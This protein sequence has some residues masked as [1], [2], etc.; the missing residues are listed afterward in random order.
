MCIVADVVFY[1]DNLI[2]N[3]SPS[4]YTLVNATLQEDGSIIIQPKGMVS[5]Y[6]SLTGG[7][8]FA[9]EVLK[10]VVE[11]SGSPD[12]SGNYNPKGFSSLNIRYTK[13]DERDNN[14][15]PL[16][17]DIVE[18]G[19][20]YVNTS[21]CKVKPKEVESLS[22]TVKNDSNSEMVLFGIG[23][24]QSQDL[25]P[26]QI[27]SVLNESSI[28]GDLITSTA[29]FSE[30]QFTQYL[31]TN[32]MSMSS[33][34]SLNGGNE[35]NYIEVEDYTMRFRSALM[36]TEE[37][38]QFVI[39]IRGIDTVKTYPVFHAVSEEHP[40]YGKAFTIVDPRE[41][42]PSLSDVDYEK[43]K[44][45]VWKKEQYRERLAIR[46][47]EVSDGDGGV[48]S[49]PVMVF[50]EGVADN[51]NDP[52]DM[53]GRM[54]LYVD[55]KGAHITYTDLHGKESEFLLNA[56]GISGVNF[57]TILTKLERYEDGCV[58]Y[59]QADPEPTVMKWKDDGQNNLT[60]IEVNGRLIPMP[61]ISGKMPF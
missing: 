53:R 26:Y 14:L 18:E 20:K 45:M 32:V 30:A 25:S 46:F 61:K 27:V 43:F 21:I 55:Y 51:N 36:S 9:C 52:D 28:V 6:K 12:I 17:R 44:F 11:F 49:T 57:T 40:L 60:G 23:L 15:L 50:G 56:D 19:G 5:V 24:Y 35:V 59:F 47:K 7:K 58:A 33:L 31:Q 29:S 1:E 38:E 4:E 16:N 48:V 13:S 39:P 2:G 37:K 10:Q 41:K 34:R 8:P 22:I 54:Q 3:I 42:F